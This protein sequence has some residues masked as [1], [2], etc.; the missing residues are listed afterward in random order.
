MSIKHCVI[1]FL[2]F[3]S[4]CFVSCDPVPG[5]KKTTS[6]YTYH[7]NGNYEVLDIN[8]YKGAEGKK[9]LSTENE[10]QQF[11]I[12]PFNAFDLKKIVIDL[13]KNSLYE[14]SAA[15]TKAKYKIELRGDSVF[16][17]NY[18]FEQKPVLGGVFARNKSAYMYCKSFYYYRY[19]DILT[20]IESSGS[21]VGKLN[22]ND[23]FKSDNITLGNTDYSFLSP[24]DMKNENDVVC[25]LHINYV[26]N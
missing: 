26:F 6:V 16:Y 22:F 2:F 12:T 1:Y 9:K 4:V 8:H 21:T 20:K 3:S 18:G 25:W 17:L 15:T 11:F 7:Y 10:V 13:N 23:N 14:I 24:H 5:I 19:Q